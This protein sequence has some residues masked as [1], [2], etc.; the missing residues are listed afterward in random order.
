MDTI[1][2]KNDTTMNT[3]TQ[4]EQDMSDKTG[5]NFG[6]KFANA[7]EVR[8][9]F[10]TES[11]AGC[12]GGDPAELP[13]QEELDEMAADVIENRWHMNVSWRDVVLYADGEEMGDQET[14]V[15]AMQEYRAKG[16]VTGYFLCESEEWDG[17]PSVKEI[18]FTGLDEAIAELAD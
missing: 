18:D 11:L 2:R 10:T 7:D 5:F 17:G 1:P 15:K 8:A 9:Y 3:T 16:A 4:R 6:E 13:T 12:F 14:L